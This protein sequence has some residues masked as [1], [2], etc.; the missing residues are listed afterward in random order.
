MGW[1]W[2]DLTGNFDLLSILHRNREGKMSHPTKTVNIYEHSIQ[3]VKMVQR[4]ILLLFLG[5]SAALSFLDTRTAT[6]TVDYIILHL[7]DYYNI[8]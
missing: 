5:W 3:L 2:K 4:L 7:S 8:T 1:S 6:K